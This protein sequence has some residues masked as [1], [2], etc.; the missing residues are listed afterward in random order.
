M[1][2][3]QFALRKALELA[4][5]GRQPFW[6]LCSSLLML[7]CQDGGTVKEYMYLGSS[8]KNYLPTGFGNQHLRL[9]QTRITSIKGQGHAIN[10]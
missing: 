7:S 2:D 9:P 10:V 1:C 3:V 8:R 4:G 6:Q 5:E